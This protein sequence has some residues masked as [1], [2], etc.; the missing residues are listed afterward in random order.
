MKLT[1]I[2]QVTVDGVMQGNG[3]SEVDRRAGFE[4]DGWAI[5][6]FDDEAVTYVHELVERADAF[7]FGRRTY[8]IFAP[9]W[10]AIGPG[11]DPIAD[12]FNTKPKYLASNTLTE[13]DWTNTTVLS[14]DLTGAIKELT[15]DSACELQVHGSGAL[16]RWL[17]EHDLVDELSL[18]ICPVVV[19]QGTRLFPDTGP[20]LAL[21]LVESRPFPKGITLQVYRPAG[22]PEYASAAP[23]PSAKEQ[24]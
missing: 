20:D 7:L 6:Y 21:D 17:L 1:T 12:A 15:A 3:P 9:F 13:P 2:T 18:L 8:E 5:G 24:P 4:R 11:S 10:G 23:V 19:G 16:V 14:G 22:R